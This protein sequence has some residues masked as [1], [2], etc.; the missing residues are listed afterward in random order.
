MIEQNVYVLYACVTTA[1]NNSDENLTDASVY[2]HKK[3]GYMIVG[4]HNLC[5]YKFNKWYSVIWMEK[6]IAGRP[7]R[8]NAFVAF[9]E[10]SK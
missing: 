7:D 9:S 4:K 6:P 10:L 5:G 2:F 1:E 3:M 8:S